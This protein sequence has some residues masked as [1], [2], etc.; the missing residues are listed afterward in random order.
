MSVIHFAPATNQNCNTRLAWLCEACNSTVSYIATVEY[1]CSSFL[2]NAPTVFTVAHISVCQPP[3]IVRCALTFLPHILIFGLTM[4]GK[5]NNAHAINMR[6]YR[7]KKDN[8]RVA[9][10]RALTENFPM[11]ESTTTI[12]P[13]EEKQGV[14]D[15]DFGGYYL[16]MVNCNNPLGGQLTICLSNDNDDDK[17]KKTDQSNQHLFLLQLI[18]SSIQKCFKIKHK[19]TNSNAQFLHGVQTLK[20]T[21]AFQGNYYF[22]IMALDAGYHLSIQIFPKF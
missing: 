15:M 5:S 22:Y 9:I 17:T 21:A 3:A 2:K 11:K 1:P 13:V 12:M 10:V 19:A 20:H 14:S 6:A 4:S 18:E 8:A 7:K 16:T